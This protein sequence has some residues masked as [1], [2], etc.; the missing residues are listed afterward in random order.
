ML[1]VQFDKVMMILFSKMLNT[2]D[3]HLKTQNFEDTLISLISSI[4]KIQKSHLK[5]ITIIIRNIKYRHK[6]IMEI[7]TSEICIFNSHFS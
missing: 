3:Y 5:K 1:R 7:I 2:K 4:A 6:I